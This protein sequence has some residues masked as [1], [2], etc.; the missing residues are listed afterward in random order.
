MSDLQK[1]AAARA[2]TTTYTGI[3]RELRT[4]VVFDG[5]QYTALWDTGATGT[6]IR[7]DLAQKL[8][9]QPISFT[10]IHTASGDFQSGVYIMMLELPNKVILPN[11]TVYDGILTSDIDFLIGMDVISKGDLAISNFNGQTMLTFRVPSAE[12]T[13]YVQQSNMA[14]SF[15]QQKTPGKK[16]KCPCGSGKQYKDCCGKRR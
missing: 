16:D 8:N 2:F 3:A 5:K 1:R 7:K 15:A 12:K 6:V 14:R 11:L 10:Q 4:P 13:D 9:L